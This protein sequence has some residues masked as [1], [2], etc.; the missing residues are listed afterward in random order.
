M[1]RGT[2]VSTIALAHDGL[3]FGGAGGLWKWTKESGC[4]S[5][6]AEHAGE[7]LAINDMIADASGRI[8]AG[9][10]YWGAAGMDNHGKIY[11]IARRRG[12]G[13]GGGDPAGQWDGI[14]RRW[15]DAVSCGFGAAANLCL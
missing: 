12:E 5:I 1:H 6:V 4:K 11:L 2:N 9:T 8:Y 7:T 3:I 10:V 15:A 14:Q 13:R